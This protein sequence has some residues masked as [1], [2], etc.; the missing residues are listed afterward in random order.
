MTAVEEIRAA[1]EK[2]TELKNM[3]TQPVESAYWVQGANRKRYESARE[4]YTGPEAAGSSDVATCFNRHDAELIVTLHRTIDAQLA[5]LKEAATQLAD[6][7]GGAQLGPE[8]YRAEIALARAIN[9]EA[10]Q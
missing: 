6:A 5:I 8:F 4:V 3:S 9:G 2:L 10:T 1:I 7:Y